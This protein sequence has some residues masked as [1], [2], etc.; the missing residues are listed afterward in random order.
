MSESQKTRGKGQSKVG[1]VIGRSGAKTTKVRVERYIKHPIY[2]RYIRRSKT[3]LVHDENEACQAGDK[4]E[5]IE[6]R[7]L[8][9]RKRWRL[10]KVIA[11]AERA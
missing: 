4:V 2:K 9:A 1:T 10:H 6:S 11:R 5:I 8:S 3:Y 7:P